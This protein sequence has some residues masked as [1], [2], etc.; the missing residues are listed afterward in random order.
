MSK[1]KYDRQTRLWG[2]GQILICASKLLCLN[3]DSLSSEILKNLI[4]SGVGGVTLVDNVKISKEDTKTNFF[5]D[6]DDI[7][8]SRAEIVLKNLLE[9]NP[10]VKGNF[11]DKSS[12]EFLNDV[13][14]DLGKYDIVIAANLKKEDDDKLYEIAKKAIY[15]FSKITMV[16]C[17]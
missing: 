4:L 9:L 10:D 15:E 13:N 7:D 12:S 3:S 8:K 16:I 14:N 17:A 5:V 2:E 11:I 1:D 6:A